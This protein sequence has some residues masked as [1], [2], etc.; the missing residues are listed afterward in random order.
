MNSN[1]FDTTFEK[2]FTRLQNLASYELIWA[3]LSLSKSLNWACTSKLIKEN[4]NNEWRQKHEQEM[5]FCGFSK[6]IE[7]EKGVMEKLGH[8]IRLVQPSH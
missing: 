1:K 8:G 6:F 5:C 2:H 4:K 7:I 3:D